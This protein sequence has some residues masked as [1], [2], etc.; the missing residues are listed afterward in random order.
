MVLAERFELT[1]PTPGPCGSARI[2][3][4]DNSAV[5]IADIATALEMYRDTKGGFLATFFPEWP[6]VVKIDDRTFRFE[7]KAPLPILDYLMANILITPAKDNKPEELQSGVGSGPYVVTEADRGTGNYLLDASPNYWGA[8]PNLSQVQ[9]RFLPEEST[10]VVSLR[11]GEVTS[12]TPSPDG[13]GA[14][15]RPARVTI[16]TRPGTG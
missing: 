12:S 7:T 6:T 5:E 11:S 8:K 9:V 10:R 2:R 13:A 4:S 15:P 3:Y 16:E 1:Q 14:A